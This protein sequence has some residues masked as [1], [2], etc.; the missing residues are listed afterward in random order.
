MNTLRITLPV[1][2]LHC[3]GCAKAVEDAILSRPGTVSAVVNLAASSATIE[4]LPEN[5]SLSDIQE[6][7]RA[8]GYDLQ[9]GNNP[10]ETA[11]NSE[12]AAR[13]SLE[14]RTAGA[15][16][17]SLPLVVLSMFFMDLPFAHWWMWALAT[18]VVF[19]LGRSFFVGAAKQLRYR[20]ANMD[21]LVALSTGVAYLFS[22]FNTLFPEFWLAKGVQP[23]VYFETASVII[24][25]VLL[26]RCLE[27]RAKNRSTSSI[28]KLMGLQPQTVA[29]VRPDGQIVQTGVEQVV[30]GD[31]VW[32]KPGEKIAVD[33]MVAAG[34]SCVDESMLSGEPLPV[35]KQE[36]MKVYAGTINQRGS[37]RF[38]AEKVGAE[39]LL[40]HI[41]R[42][43]QEAQGSKAPVQRLVDRIAAV[44][45][46]TVVLIALIALVGWTLFGGANGLTHGLLAFVTV[47]IIACPCALGLATPTAIMVGIGRAAEQGILIKDAESLEAAKKIEAVVLDKTG[48]ITEGKPAVTTVLWAND[49]N[50]P[51]S[52]LRSLEMRSEHPLAEAVVQYFSSEPECAVAGF[53]SLTGKGVRGV[54]DGQTYFVGSAQ[55]LVENRIARGE[56]LVDAAKALA[57]QGQTVVWFADE[58]SALALVAVSDRIKESSRI[59]IRQLRSEGIAVYMLTGDNVAT[60]TAVAADV[61][62][63]G[64]LAETLPRQKAE[65]VRQLQAEGKVVAMVGDGINDS[66]ALAQADVSIAMGQGSDIAIDTAQMTV[67]ASDLSKI[68]VTIRLSKQ[69]V[70]VVRQN[71]FWAFVYNLVGIPVAAGA[72]YAVNGFLL[73]PMLAGGAMALS[74]VCVVCNS[75]RLSDRKRPV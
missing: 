6:A 32:V 8:K 68:P 7:V 61:G 1:L 65:F 72:L 5:V 34:E 53:E 11:E 54:V 40:A 71:L 57:A 24:A 60:A 58:Q 4:Y 31:V 33:G 63:D 35:P 22:A 23:H 19:W 51:V 3:A 13:R 36:G 47:M 42:M 75:L 30:V 41:I 50:R 49:D 25:F 38:R 15:I 18:P 55:L 70:S 28:K 69:T 39:T 9:T 2:H 10:F 64:F 46:P 73:D 17:L 62:V 14:H 21:T 74:S 56:S 52:V 44:F 20:S 59:A 48:T 67:V 27:E 26:G 16:G 66:A 43:V 37:L 45:V 12:A 29:L